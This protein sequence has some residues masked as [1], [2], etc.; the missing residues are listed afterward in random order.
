M[1]FW[2][3]LSFTEPEHLVPLAKIAEEVGFHGAFASDHLFVPEKIQSKYPYS[4]DGSPPFLS[5]T[6]W[7]DAFVTCS[8]LLTATT[9]LEVSTAVYILPLRNPF[10]AAKAVGTLCLLSGGRFALGAGLGWMREEFKACHQDFGTR[11]KR[12]DEMVAV[13]RTLWKGGMVEYHGEYYDFGRLEMSPAPKRPIPIYVGGGSDAALR[14]AARVGDGW[15]GAGNAPEEVPGIMDRLRR[16]RKEY[17]RERVPF[18]TIVAVSVPP[19]LSL[20][21]RLEDA[22]V[23]ALVSWPL[24]YTLGPGATLELKRKALESYGNEVIARLR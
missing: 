13:M 19:E 24:A 3:S 8:A 6:P 22:G 9:R 15:I 23:T 2:Q 7:P 16:L 18:E 4:A 11:A 14:R 5:T 20:F 21:Q 17:D 10:E 1:K 12:F